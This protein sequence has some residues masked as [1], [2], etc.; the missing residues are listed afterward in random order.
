MS[1]AFAMASCGQ[2]PEGEPIV[3]TNLDGSEVETVAE[4]EPEATETSEP[5]V[6]SACRPAEFETVTLPPC[7][8]DPAHHPIKPASHPRRRTRPRSRGV[9][10]QAAAQ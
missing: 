9:M 10:A 5:E 6:A 4:P 3:R 2:Q 7:L 1:S 8:A